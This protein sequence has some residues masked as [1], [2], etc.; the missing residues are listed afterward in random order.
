MCKETTVSK[1]IYNY[2]SD[3]C[4][5]NYIAFSKFYEKFLLKQK[6]FYQAKYKRKEMFEVS[7]E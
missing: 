1:N 7:D 5:N 6:R 2:T 4:E 3:L